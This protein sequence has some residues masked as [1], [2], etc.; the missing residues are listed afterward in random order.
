MKKL[1]SHAYRNDPN[2]LR[3]QFEPDGRFGFPLIR[4]Q[5]ID[6]ENIELIALSDTKRNDSPENCQKI[7]HGFLDDYR[8]TIHYNKPDLHREKLSQYKAL[9]AP[10]NS[11]YREMDPWRAIE[12]IGHSRWVGCHWQQDWERPV[13]PS[14]SWGGPASFEFCFD[15]VERGSIVAL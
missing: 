6:L 8:F 4:K 3:N 10:D 9:I 14:I 2:F 15:G 5:E 1:N 13:I 11:V 12:N 7:V